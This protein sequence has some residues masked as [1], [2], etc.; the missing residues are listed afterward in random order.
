MVMYKTSTMEPL[1]T[2]PHRKG[3]IEIHNVKDRFN[4]TVPNVEF[5]I[6]LYCTF[7][8]PKRGKPLYINDK[9][10]GLKVSFIM[11]VTLYTLRYK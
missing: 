9:I 1:L 2:S 7:D 3:T 8:S 5:L 10:A 6:S 11:E 4:S